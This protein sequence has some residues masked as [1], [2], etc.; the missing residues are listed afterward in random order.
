MHLS[1][2]SYQLHSSYVN[3][4]NNQPKHTPF[5]TSDNSVSFTG[6]INA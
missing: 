6:I 5:K 4:T 1:L 2:I 3:T